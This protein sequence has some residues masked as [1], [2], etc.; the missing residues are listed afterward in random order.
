MYTDLATLCVSQDQALYP[1]VVQMDANRLGIVLVVDGQ[2]RLIGT[3][4]DGD[5]RRA[6]LTKLALE[7]PIRS[8]LA[9]KAGTPYATPITARMGQESGAY[10]ALL[11]RHGILHLPLLDEAD[12]VVGVVTMEEFLPN[13]PL[14]LR[15]VVMAGG[16][17]SRLSPLT[18]EI[19]KPMLPVGDRPLLELIIE[20][21]RDAGVRHVKLST[22]HKPEKI[23]AHFRDGKQFGVELSYVTE[24]RPL[25]TAGALGLQEPPDTTTLVMNGDILTQVDF[26]AML[27]YH[28]EHEA[29]FTVCVRHYELKVPYGL[30]RCEGFRVTGLSEKPLV[31]SFV[32]AGTYLLEPDVYQFIPK[33]ERMDMTELIQQLIKSGRTVVSFPI[34][35]H[36]LDIGQLD[37]YA[38]AQEQVKRWEQSRRKAKHRAA[39]FQKTVS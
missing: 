17:G 37:D 16:M 30:V 21:L 35:E 23:E 36:W 2:R 24:D 32:N 15:A 33:G 31:S 38:E 9:R 19:P 1:A 6:L 29:D 39:P 14:S 22:H 13:Q 28:R 3:I 20:Q 10:L 27:A 34:R 5:I 11:K 26:R 18:E 25:G 7:Q 12:R 4:T 8:L